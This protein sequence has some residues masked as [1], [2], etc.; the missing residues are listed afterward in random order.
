LQ[1]LEGMEYFREGSNLY[2]DIC[3]S[4]GDY[5]VAKKYYEDADMTYELGL[6]SNKAVDAWEKSLNWQL[7]L[8]MA[9]EISMH[10]HDVC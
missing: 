5:L 10:T 3:R 6:C 4:Y 7:C 9:Q 1:K 2:W 8:A